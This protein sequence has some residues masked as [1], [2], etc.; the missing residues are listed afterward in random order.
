MIKAYTAVTSEID[1]P[2][3]AAEEILAGLSPGKNLKKHSIGIISCFSEFDDTG[4][5][6][7]ICDALPFE[8]I[9]STT[10]LCAANQQA[11]QIIF[12]I[13]VLTSDDCSF[14]TLRLPIGDDFEAAADAQMQAFLSEAEEK[15]AVFLS[16]FPLMITVSGDRILSALDGAS[17]GVPFFGTVAVDHNPDYSTAKTIHNGEA[18][19]DEAVLGAIY[20]KPNIEYEISSLDE[21][22]IRSQRAIITESDGNILMGVNGKRALSY[23]IEIGLTKEELATGLGVVPFV[24]DHKD[25]TKP[26]ARAVF[27]LTPDG[28][29]VCGGS[30]TVGATLA[31]GR[32]DMAD[33]LHT[34]KSM[35]APLVDENSAILS[36]SC[37]ARYLVLGAD[38]TAEAEAVNEICGDTPYMFTCSGGELCPLPDAAG[39]LRNLSHN[40]TNVVCRIS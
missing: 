4:A 35:I 6:K 5:L 24:V 22:K 40:F 19:R 2:K 25:G 28:H 21:A 36:Y 10:C 29:A 7:A 1:D 37:I 20:G 11:D 18:F 34:A 16:F 31:I 3:A 13:T 33:V 17:G 15:P 30:M 12:A 26:V 9:G 14:K 23:L 32:I 38:N 8:C 39:R 27:G